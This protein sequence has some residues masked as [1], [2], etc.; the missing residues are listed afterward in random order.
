MSKPKSLKSQPI[1]PTLELIR[2]DQVFASSRSRGPTF[3]SAARAARN[4]SSTIR[5]F[6]G[7]TRGS[8]RRSDGSCY[9][10]DL[11]S[12]NNTY[13]DGQKLTPFQPVRL[14]DGC[15][16]KIVDFELVFR[17]PA[18]GLR[19]DGEERSTV[20]RIARRPQLDSTGPAAETASRGLQ[21]DTRR[22]S[23]TRR[24]RSERKARPG[25][26]RADG[27]ISAGGA[28]LHRDDRARRIAFVAGGSSPWRPGRRSMR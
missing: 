6:L 28:R 14:R 19:K 17:A 13:V 20:L 22:D 2:D 23:G 21:G 25:T 12:Q 16:I 3:T 15:R 9:L 1:V 24:D 4:F 5:R 11:D 26:R 7:T 8:R 10:V 18:V 27:G